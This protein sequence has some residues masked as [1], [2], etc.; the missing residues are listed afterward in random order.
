MKAGIGCSTPATLERSG[1]LDLISSILFYLPSQVSYSL[2]RLTA[3]QTQNLYI[4]PESEMSHM[5]ALDLNPLFPGA[6]AKPDPIKGGLCVTS[7]FTYNCLA[8]SQCK[9][10]A[11]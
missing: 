11:I 4:G 2:Q 5:K 8:V 7:F 1:G 10:A 3:F 9:A 6:K